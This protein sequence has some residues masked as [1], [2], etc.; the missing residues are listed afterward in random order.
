VHIQINK[1]CIND[2]SGNES[3]CVSSF[4]AK[5][6]RASQFF[7]IFSNNPYSSDF[8]RFDNAK[9]LQNNIVFAANLQVLDS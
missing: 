3:I 6:T 9:F 1:R 5:Q 2:I 8:F 7:A 4:F